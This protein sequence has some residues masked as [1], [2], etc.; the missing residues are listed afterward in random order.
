[1]K[2]MRHTLFCSLRNKICSQYNWISI[3]YSPVAVYGKHVDHE[4]VVC[5]LG[6]ICKRYNCMVMED[7]MYVLWNES[8][9]VW[10][11]IF[12]QYI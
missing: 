2:L 9:A 4:E 7:Y 5:E 3:F 12:C 11:C 8:S 6:G 1:M 10:V